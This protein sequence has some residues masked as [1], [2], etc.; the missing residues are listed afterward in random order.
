MLNSLPLPGTMAVLPAP[1]NEDDIWHA[2]SDG[3]EVSPDGTTLAVAEGNDVVLYDSTTLTER[4][5]L[6]GHSDLVRSLQFSHDG[7]LL[8]SGSADHSAV[9]WDLATGG[10][11]HRLT[12]HAGAVL[13]LAFSPDDGTLYTG[14]LDSHVLVWDIT[15]RRQ[16]VARVVDRAPPSTHLAAAV[17][18]PDGGSV[19]YLGSAASGKNLQF[20]DVATGQVDAPGADPGADPLATWL[21]PDDRHLVTV[22]G[23]TLRVRDT[24]NNQVVAERTV[25][26][27]PIT[28][29]ASTPEGAFVVVGERSG[30]MDRVEARTLAPGGPRLQFNHPVKAVAT[31]TRD[32]A[33]ALLDDKTY[34]VVDLA[35]GS[36]L[37]MGS[38]GFTPTSAGVS[39]DGSRLAIGGSLGEVGLL[40]L[41]SQEWIAPS[42]AAHRQFVDG[43][44]FAR[45][46]RT[47]VT[48][49]FDGGVR[50]WDAETGASLAGV[51]VGQQ[52]PAVATLTPD[53]LDAVV[54]SRDGAVYRLETA[55]DQ[56][57]AF[58]CAVAGRNFT[59]QEWQAVF[60]DQPYRETCQ[61]L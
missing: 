47:F 1:A 53:G 60:G 34:A 8:A 54:A 42:T 50:L 28:A 7:R 49:S 16:F 59:N 2:L 3:L 61:T 45:D 6:R 10:V 33:V 19:A 17:P 58:A 4:S 23:R 43:V 30:G 13:G 55:F 5:R 57:T 15:G 56:W 9:L 31:G 18:S 21:P 12:G 27:S 40:D 36:V 44:A 46:G 29:L 11:V 41:D 25:A 22:A 52:S 26:L 37:T 20:L 39:P 51:Q 48:S 38:L 35:E 24:G 14:G 32:T